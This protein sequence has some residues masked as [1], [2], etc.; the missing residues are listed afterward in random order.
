MTYC[1]FFKWHAYDMHQWILIHSNKRTETAILLKLTMSSYSTSSSENSS[2]SDSDSFFLAPRDIVFAFLGPVWL[3]LKWKKY[4]LSDH[5]HIT[6]VTNF[7]QGLVVS[8]TKVCFDEYIEQIGVDVVES[9]HKDNM[10]EG[11]EDG[12]NKEDHHTKNVPK[13]SRPRRRLKDKRN[14]VSKALPKPKPRQKCVNEKLLENCFICNSTFNVLIPGVKKAHIIWPFICKTCKTEHR[15]STDLKCKFCTT[16]HPFS[17]QG[18]S[19]HIKDVCKSSWSYL[20]GEVLEYLHRCPYCYRPYLSR[21]AYETHLRMCSMTKEERNEQKKKY[22]CGICDQV[23]IDHRCYE[24]HMN[25][26][27]GLTPFECPMC[28]KVFSSVVSLTCHKQKVHK[29]KTHQ[30]QFCCKIFRDSYRLKV[31]E[32]DH[33]GEKPFGCAHCDKRF[34]DQYQLKLHMRIHTSEK[35][36]SCSFC[37]KTFSKQSNMRDHEKGVHTGEMSYF[38]QCCN[39]G[40]LRKDYCARHEKTCS[41]RMQVVN[42]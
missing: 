40:F 7:L 21:K 18:L 39:K 22:T 34:K 29:P 16:S 26:H 41:Q 33:T 4:V 15:W 14:L 27:M 10:S 23:F 17:L 2:S 1:H 11:E 38:C 19:L 42:L 30:C 6:K 24:G 13:V 25:E 37:G 8:S 20:S 36:Y 3:V 12:M 9:D 5:V 32:R 28:P 35:P 31:H